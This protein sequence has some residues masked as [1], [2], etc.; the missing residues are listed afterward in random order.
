MNRW[1]RLVTLIGALVLGATVRAGNIITRLTDP[2]LAD[3]VAITYGVRLVDVTA[4]APFALYAVPIGENS[5]LIQAAMASDNRI[6]W[7]EDEAGF[8]FPEY[9]STTGGSIG[10]IF[11]PGSS[12]A[13]N[14]NAWNQVNFLGPRATT[15]TIR[16]GVIDTGFNRVSG[17]LSRRVVGVLNCFNV[18]NPSDLPLGL[19]T[20]QNGSPD[21]AVGHG[22][23]V[24]GLI[25]QMAPTANFLIAKAADSDGRASTWT[26]LKSTVF[27]VTQ[28][29]KLINISLGGIQRFKAFTDMLDWADAAD[30]IV[31]A[32]IGNQNQNN[33]LFPAGFAKAICVTGLQ[34]NNVKASFSNW[35][36]TALVAAPATGLRSLWWNGDAAVWSGTS[37]A[38]PIVTGAIANCLG[39]LPDRTR[40]QV[41]AAL[42]KSGTNIDPLNS[43]YSGKL[44][45]LLNV[46]ALFTEL[47][48]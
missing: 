46:Q 8:E 27:C 1:T 26:V 32:P 36:S 5:T 33:T 41:V 19:D 4:N 18:R 40:T 24:V 7:T 13:V 29:A 31:I 47:S 39:A 43:A 9:Q 15:R 28:G 30:V 10:A 38:A 11:D 17:P 37:F 45:T 16:V 2:S 21:E 42:K 12:Y 14:S 35:D 44:G 23:M 3:A 25:H 48:Q 22:S 34:P 20:N 6:V